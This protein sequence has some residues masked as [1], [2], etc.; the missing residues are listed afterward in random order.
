MR[1]E[2]LEIKTWEIK[3]Y[4]DLLSVI[5]TLIDLN[6]KH[7]DLG[8]RMVIIAEARKVTYETKTDE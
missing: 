6:F 2:L 8:N 3:N 4:E 1:S 7:E 5:A